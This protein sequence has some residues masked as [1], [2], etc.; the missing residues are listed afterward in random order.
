MMD[1]IR[2]PQFLIPL[3]LPCR[4]CF[5]AAITEANRRKIMTTESLYE[6]TR[7]LGEIWCQRAAQ[8][9]TMQA[10]LASYLRA[11]HPDPQ[12]DHYGPTTM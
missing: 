10:W 2:K 7:C 1:D 8:Q 6:R 9:Q 12:G 4:D 3:D 5:D 11:N